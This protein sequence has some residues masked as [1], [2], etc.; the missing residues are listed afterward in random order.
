M[1]DGIA[2]VSCRPD[3]VIPCILFTLQLDEEIK[4]QTQQRLR[5]K[6][7]ADRGSDDGSE[8]D[9]EEE[10]EVLDEEDEPKLNFV[11]PSSVQLSMSRFA[12]EALALS[13]EPSLD[14][15]D[16]ASLLQSNLSASFEDADD[17]GSGSRAKA[18]ITAGT[19]IPHLGSPFLDAE[20]AAEWAHHLNGPTGKE[21]LSKGDK[22]KKSTGSLAG[23]KAP[24]GQA[25]EQQ[26]S[27]YYAD[28]YHTIRDGLCGAIVDSL[29]AC[30]KAL[31]NSLAVNTAYVS[32]GFDA[33]C[34]TASTSDNSPSTV[35]V[36][37]DLTM[38]LNPSDA[39][40]N[41]HTQS[42]LWPIAQLLH[43][44][45]IKSIL[46]LY[47]ET[48]SSVLDANAFYEV[49]TRYLATLP[50]AML[51]TLGA[52]RPFTCATLSDPSSIKSVGSEG[53]VVRI[54]LC[55]RSVIDLAAAL[56]SLASTDPSNNVAFIENTS[57]ILDKKSG[58]EA[59]AVKTYVSDDL[60]RQL[61]WCS[62]LYFLPIAASGSHSLFTVDN[63]LVQRHI[64]GLFPHYGKHSAAPRVTVCLGGRSDIAKLKVLDSLLDS[65]RSIACNTFCYCVVLTYPFCY[66]QSHTVFIS[67]ELAIPFVSLVYNISFAQHQRLCQSLAS[68]CTLILRKARLRGVDLVLPADFLIGDEPLDPLTL[69]GASTEDGL[70]YP[71]DVTT[72]DIATIVASSQ[73]VVLGYVYD[74]GKTSCGLLESV[75]SA[76]SDLLVIWGAVGTNEY[77]SF[78]AGQGTLTTALLRQATVV[79]T[80]ERTRVWLIGESTV[81]HFTSVID[82]DEEYQGDISRSPLIDQ[83]SP[84]SRWFRAILGSS[85]AC[86]TLSR[87]ER[88][89]RSEGE[90]QGLFAKRTVVEEGS[91][92]EEEE[93]EED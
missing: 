5:Q 81:R 89:A 27:A 36:S 40:C 1:Y 2:I 90:I 80:H 44:T 75:L 83:L 25:T 10:G 82:A 7:K 18:G 29:S 33:A 11:P 52:V 8:S 70:D 15:L 42:A 93:E 34:F 47:D 68:T 91:D 77:A 88:A 72:C 49:L 24:K 20:A 9:E 79:D 43:S 45:S 50:K 38:L 41:L 55:N 46:V 63:D 56:E 60:R 14:S 48:S 26:T 58:S 13:T 71:G 3:C 39:F 64:S 87:V 67:G 17:W 65:V 66:T 31:Q 62:A 35:A 92:E 6:R 28:L 30:D 32:S 54:L 37:L 76:P 51:K 21:E 61:A 4:K 12:S 84:D 16:L 86:Q 73:S 59:V 85:T 69:T 22:N 53:D 78:Q 23:V 74:I 19:K 57:H